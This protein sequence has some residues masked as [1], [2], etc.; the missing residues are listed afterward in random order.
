MASKCSQKCVGLMSGSNASLQFVVFLSF[1][2]QF[3]FYVII[4]IMISFG[5]NITNILFSSISHSLY[6]VLYFKDVT[7]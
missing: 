6:A 7:C 5:L 2:F 4:D 1:D 3:S